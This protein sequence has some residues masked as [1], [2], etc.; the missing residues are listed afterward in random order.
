MVGK[1]ED[2]CGAMTLE[3]RRVGF[4]VRM[5]V[6]LELILRGWGMGIGSSSLSMCVGI[7]KEGIRYI[8]ASTSYNCAALMPE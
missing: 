3:D 4:K 6:P 8:F 2:A 7:A 5:V 1:L